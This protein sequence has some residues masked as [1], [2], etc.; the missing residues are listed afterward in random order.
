MTEPRKQERSSKTFCL[1][2]HTFALHQVFLQHPTLCRMTMGF[3]FSFPY[4]LYIVF[5]LYYYLIL[6]SLPNI[7]Y[8]ITIIPAQLI[9]PA[10]NALR[11]Q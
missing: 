7:Y 5:Y 8:K 2:P 10:S 3:H 9:H 4:K 1:A 11:A 6:F